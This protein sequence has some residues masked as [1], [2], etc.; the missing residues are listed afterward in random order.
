MWDVGQGAGLGLTVCYGV[1]QQHRGSI[2]VKSEAGKG[3]TVTVTIP[4]R[5]SG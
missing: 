4:V 5:Q 2:G 1:I 3:T